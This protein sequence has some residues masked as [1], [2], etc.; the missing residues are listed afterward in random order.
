MQ[1]LKDRRFARGVRP[2]W[3]TAALAAT[4]AALPL[5]A[6]DTAAAKADPY[7]VLV[8]TKNATVGAAEGV[9]ALQAAAPAD[10]TFDV[11]ADASTFTDTG[12]APYKAVVFL[13]TT[14]DVLNAAQEAAFEKYFRSGGGF[15]GIGAAITTEPSSSFF[16][17]ILG[18]RAS[19]EPTTA[20]QATVK[21]ADRGHAAGGK[22]L[23][24]YYH[25]S[26]RWFNFADNVR[27]FSHVIATVDE[28]TYTGGNTKALA[29]PLTN[30]HP[31]VWC[32]DYQGGRSFYTALGNTAEGFADP[33]FRKHLGG[34]VQ[35]AAGKADPVYSDCGAT[36]LANYQQTKISA[37]PNLNEPIGFDQL[38]DGRILQTAR[39][40]Q[41]RLHDPAKG[42]STVIATIPVYT[43]SEDGLYGP[44][45]DNDFATNKWVYLYYAPPTVRIRK[46]DG[47]MAD[48]TTPT[49]S[50][51]T[52]AADPCVWQD[53][54][55]GYFQLSRFKFVD[56]ENPTI[57]LESEQKIMQVANNRGA[58][59]HVAGD[60]DFDKHN[61]LW[62]VTGDDTPA[63]GGNSGGFGPFNDQKT[64][65]TQTLR[66]T[67]ATGG[68]FTLTFNGQTT[69]ALAHNA[70]A[71][72]IQ[73][74][75]E[76]LSN[77]DPGDIAVTGGPINS[78]NVSVNFRGAFAETNVNQI[79]GDTAALEG[80]G[81]TLAATT[82][83]NSEGGLFTAPFVDARRSAQNTNDLRGKVLRI[84][85]QN[86][87]SYTIPAGN[88][89]TLGQA[90]TRPE[91][92]AMGFRNPFRIQVDSNDV[93]YVTDYS[94]DSNVPQ[95]FRGP[96]GTG[97]VEI[98]R[99][100]S[101][102]GWP[103]CYSP[104]LPYYRW[105]FNT[106][107]P[108]D[109]TPTPHECNNPDRGPQNSSRW[110][111]DGGPT[112]EPGLEYG[113]PIARPDL[114]YSFRDNTPGTL[115]GTPCFAYYNGSGGTCP[116][117]FPELFT[118]GVAPHGAT[119]YEYDPANPNP[120]KLPPYYDDA[121]FLGEFGQDT[122]RE[123]RL[124]ADDKVFKINRLLDCGPVQNNRTQPFECDNPMDMQF[125]ADGAFYL[126]TYGDGF[127]N[128]NADAGLYKWEYVKGQRAPSAV[129]NADRTDGP[130][131]LTVRFSSEGTTDP[132]PGDALTYAWDFDGD[133]TV[134]STAE[135][136][137]HTYTATGV[138][139]AKLTV[140]DSS[141][142]QD[143]KST[144][145]TV[146]NTAPTIKIEVP[147][148]G[149]F[150]EWGQKI[151]YRVT[152]TDPEDGTIDC[153]KVK[154][155]F[156][157]VHDQHG[158]G[159][160]ERLG[161]SGTLETVADDASHGGYIAG[162][163]SA[164]YTDTGGAGGTPA[165]TTVEQNVVQIKRQQVEYVQEESGTSLANV[166]AGETD[167]FG[168][169]VRGSL[170]N[171]DWIALNGRYTLANMDKQITFRYAGG[172]AANP[173][174]S[175]RAAIEIRTGSA[176]GPIVKTVTLK[177]TGTNNNT[178]TSQTFDLD[179][180]GS[181]RLYFVF[182]A[183]DAPGAPASGFGNLNWIEFGGEG[184]TLPPES[185]T[186]V[187]GTV[188]GTVPAT[189]GLTL[190]APATFGAFTPGESRDYT[191]STTADV[192][193]TAG[194][195]ALTV[196]DPGHLSNGAFSLPEPLQ[197]AFS[198]ST[199]D[200]PVSHESVD[201]TFK[202]HIGA[203]DAL[204]TGTYS[205]TLTFTLSTTT[206]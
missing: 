50:A 124:D 127:F 92:Y 45:I 185:S 24:E 132:D 142:K 205:R 177:S 113:P 130:A 9:A 190:G 78:A 149:D 152:V 86:D 60:I 35:W 180:E 178:Y 198:K 173:A 169:Q 10:A 38:P 204:R 194:D 87:G 105:N 102:Y 7:S 65:E 91:I 79:T 163:I 101:N 165:L 186:S 77:I 68:T 202:Q 83:A 203:N 188:G 73:A 108:L 171:G 115:Q 95:D 27:G 18:T 56:G 21:V 44:A 111:R 62:L 183:I 53:T 69:A 187:E 153:A 176:T 75:L 114:W 103:L 89:F 106:S 76:A 167:P 61:N 100:P 126:L 128:A 20:Q 168:G 81:A 48:V 46:C 17:D 157:L 40:G 156:V 117:L 123:V 1:Q 98:V 49:G 182:R 145:I 8:F 120:N 181:Q 55:A 36:V 170:D 154:V 201:V 118:G 11:T 159:E 148:D 141:G 155:T 139:T 23:P 136:A 47:T 31:V 13:N 28:N 33:D 131:P 109:A 4:L 42:T 125:G 110:V 26:D 197:V 58:C 66:I 116:Q 172:S 12:L 184:V 134:D 175:D 32:K 71:A 80:T 72:Q 107:T 88:L 191:A 29:T 112:V 6:A 137:T 22:A 192:L 57:D 206:P 104:D 160:D 151:P 96:A 64:N 82:A 94:P 195:A 97:R 196:S 129:L 164:S 166:P 14:G 200:A 63:G 143:I 41:L 193:S 133:G 122:L 70:T 30:D 162:G 39:G 85:V 2:R 174:G 99:K 158:H 140:T 59:C 121:V 147:T 25:R 67:N 52:V 74:A 5:A 15:L 199:W 189:L 135:N 119:K 51:P 146:G 90:K 179:F 93:A 161:C 3:R 54:W 43:N 150:F 16:T 19:G 138:Y 84:S 37:P 144:V 34:A